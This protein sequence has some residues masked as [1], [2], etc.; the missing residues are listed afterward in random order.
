[1]TFTGWILQLYFPVVVLVYNTLIT[2]EFMMTS[3]KPDLKIV[4]GW[5]TDITQTPYHVAI[6]TRKGICGSS[7]ISTQ[8]LLTVAHC[9]VKQDATMKHV[10]LIIGVDD[11]EDYANMPQRNG[12]LP[13][14][15][16]II[17]HPNYKHWYFMDNFGQ[18]NAASINDICLLRVDH[19]LQFGKYI[20]K[21]GLPWKA[22]DQDTTKKGLIVS[23]FGM[24]RLHGPKSRKLFSTF[25]QIMTDEECENLM[26]LQGFL[27]E[28]AF[29]TT[30]N[31]TGHACNFDSGGGLVY[32]DSIPECPIIIG[33]VS[34]GDCS[35]PPYATKFT[36][37]KGYK[38]WIEE[39]MEM[40]HRPHSNKSYTYPERNKITS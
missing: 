32:K 9:I 28:K 40:Y 34:I 14:A 5:P 3:E 30:S 21:V 38:A 4:R 20:K 37:V 2:N 31:G 23:G 36:Q 11:R 1:M 8:W 13:R 16:L 10:D 25:L 19:Q 29:C 26:G 7:I 33:L 12:R 17:C 35:F 18:R 6:E 27:K 15:D 39:T 24:R 22:F